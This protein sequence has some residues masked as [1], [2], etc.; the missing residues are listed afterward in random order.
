M[1]PVEDFEE[2]ERQHDAMAEDIK[3]KRK[4]LIFIISDPTNR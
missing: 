2:Q 3:T 4:K 1:Q